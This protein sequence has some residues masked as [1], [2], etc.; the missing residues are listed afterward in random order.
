MTY[1][2]ED[3]T[4]HIIIERKNNKNTY[5]RL[6]DTNTIYITTS[7]LTTKRQ[8]L[9]LIKD[10][11][12]FIIKNSKKMEQK[13]EKENS[14]FY[15][16]KE[17]NI[18]IYPDSDIEFVGSRIYVKNKEAL[19]KWYQ[20]EMK[21]I[22]QERLDYQYHQFE[23]AI[24]YPIL[25]IR[26]MKTRWG[27]CNKR[28]NSVTLNAELLRYDIEKIDYVIVHELSH[29]IYFDHSKNFW[30]QVSKYFPDYKRVRKE[31]KN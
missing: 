24:P 20:K 17:Y 5:L 31:L 8:I 4:Y 27:V 13:K 29:F 10:N 18:I 28:D 3:I 25:K 19:E 14:F 2:I 9:N 23:E 15:L 30:N 6:K 12:K 7:F 11:E 26:K 22:F 16:G 1:T 21:R